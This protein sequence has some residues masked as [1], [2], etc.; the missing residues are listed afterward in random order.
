MLLHHRLHFE[1]RCKAALEH[2]MFGICFGSLQSNSPTLQQPEKPC[3]FKLMDSQPL[4]APSPYLAN[5]CEA[6]ART[7]FLS[8]PLERGR[9]T[10]LRPSNLTSITHNK[11]ERQR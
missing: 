9:F 10:S 11:F 2:R 4:R 6:V 3:D 1:R 7:A 8:T 5:S